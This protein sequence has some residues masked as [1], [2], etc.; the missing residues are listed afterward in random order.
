M[1]EQAGDG[2]EN[3]PRSPGANQKWFACAVPARRGSSPCLPGGFGTPPCRYYGRCARSSL[4]AGPRSVR[5]HKRGPETGSVAERRLVK[6]ACGAPRGGRLFARDAPRLASVDDKRR[7]AALRSPSSRLAPLRRASPRPFRT[8][9][10]QKAPPAPPQ[11]ANDARLDA[12]EG[13][14][15]RNAALF[16]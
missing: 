2:P 1:M 7:L 12:G 14:N 3:R 4:M 10:F 15:D 6:A 8:A 9:E 13:A 5:T 11:G 16:S